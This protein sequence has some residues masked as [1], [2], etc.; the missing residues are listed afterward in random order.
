MSKLY[1]LGLLNTVSHDPSACL[2]SATYNE[3]ELTDVDYVHF[4]ESMLTRRKKANLFPVLSINKC[5]EYF[6]ISIDEIDCV[7]TDYMENK[8]WFNSTP[9]NRKQFSDYIKFNLKDINSKVEIVCSHHMAHAFSAVWPTGFPTANVLVMDGSGSEY[10]TGTIFNF[11]GKNFTKISQQKGTGIGLL[12]TLIT[13]KLGFKTGEEGKTMGLAPFGIAKGK[14]KNNIFEGID[15]D[16]FTDYSNILNRF[17]SHSLKI[18]IRQRDEQESVMSDKWIELACNVQTELERTIIRTITRMS[19][20]KLSPNLCYAG[21]LALNCS[22]NSKI[23]ESGHFENIFIQPN[24]GDAGITLGLAIAGL[25]KILIE[26]GIDTTNLWRLGPQKFKK[27]SEHTWTNHDI[28]I[29]LEKLEIPYSLRCDDVLVEKILEN[30]VIAYFEGGWEFG[31]R[32][33]GHRSFLAS[34][35]E[36]GM[37]DIMNK[38]IKHREPYR[39]FAP[40]LLEEDFEKYFHGSSDSC[41]FM[42]TANRTK[43]SA[44]LDIPAVVHVD[45]TARVQVLKLGDGKISFLLKKYK[46]KTGNSVLI[47]TSFNDNNEPIVFSPTDAISCF[48]RTN[49]DILVLEDVIIL[50][51][52]I[53][54]IPHLLQRVTFESKENVE[55]EYKNS[56]QKNFNFK[57]SDEAPKAYI[58]RKLLTSLY[59]RYAHSF[60]KLESLITAASKR[61]TFFTDIYHSKILENNKLL[62]QDA[63]LLFFKDDLTDLDSIKSALVN[64]RHEEIII[65]LYNLSPHLKGFTSS[66]INIL[67][68]ENDC[69]ISFEQVEIHEANDPIMDFEFNGSFSFNEYLKDGMF[70]DFSE[71]YLVTAQ[72][73]EM[74][75][76]IFSSK[77]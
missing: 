53:S 48:L 28:T 38:K 42:L 23:Y 15:G 24:C 71:R 50:R 9:K 56:F 62:K 21:G 32:A 19:K 20:D 67:Y 66:N 25:Q 70:N 17:P 2:I 37:K 26:K 52:N 60:E 45:N 59:F 30:N 46:T 27:Y 4:E 8:S 74:N 16:Y 54:D 44:A 29:L 33:L 3:K 47:N 41:E 5:L 31:P 64:T 72:I 39:P 76:R 6:G 22:V 34:P 77:S 7:A 36:A 10:E 63:Q 69:L 49:A 75:Q 73:N 57:I 55:E 40:I 1:V 43:D 14:T 58:S 68:E 13:K 12:Y 61:I 18:D 65:L 35:M 51:E 11:D